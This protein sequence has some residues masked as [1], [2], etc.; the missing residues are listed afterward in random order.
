[1][2]KRKCSFT[3][4]LQKQYPMFKKG[5]FEWEIVCKICE[6][7]ISIANK[8]ASDI[9]EHLN[10]VNTKLKLELKHH[11]PA[12]LLRSSSKSLVLRKNTSELQKEQWLSI[13]SAITCRLIH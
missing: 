2:P 12:R 5:K 6:S 13:Q 8:G 4:T 7:S 1:M 11:V 3:E 9:T 10:T